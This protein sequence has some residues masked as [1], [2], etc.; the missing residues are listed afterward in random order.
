M[1]SEKFEPLVESLERFVENTRQLG[2]IV[3]DFQPQGQIT[4]NQK[5][6]TLVTGLLEM[7][8]TKTQV[9][10]VQVPLEVFDYIDQGRNPQLYTKDCMEK[11][12]IKNEQ[13][14]GKIETF[15]KFKK[16]LITELNKMFPEE[17]EQY[18][19]HRGDT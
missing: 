7:E 10:D 18:K 15:S 9:Q 1:A 6:H 16:N 11:A 2:I 8:K 14:K 5:L 3:S 4:L 12:V 19:V 13:V 17:M